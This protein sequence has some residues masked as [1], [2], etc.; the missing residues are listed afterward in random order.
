MKVYKSRVYKRQLT[1]FTSGPAEV[2]DINDNY[3]TTRLSSTL[4]MMDVETGVICFK[5]SP[6]RDYTHPDDHIPS[7]GGGG[8]EGEKGLDRVLT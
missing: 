5:G 2:S 3:T 4:K 8:G 7:E 6:I 1:V